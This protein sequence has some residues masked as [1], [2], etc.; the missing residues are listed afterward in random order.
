MSS[1]CIA[2]ILVH[3]GHI[4]SGRTTWE[5]TWSRWVPK[6]RL[7]EDP[8]RGVWQ[9][10]K[11]GPNLTP[12]GCPNGSKSDPLNHTGPAWPKGLKKMRVLGV[13]LTYN[14]S[15]WTPRCP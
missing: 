1:L 14:G 10:V 11:M 9:G 3:I 5:T 15:D 6:P 13:K 4:G 8:G 12:S 2:S 7:N